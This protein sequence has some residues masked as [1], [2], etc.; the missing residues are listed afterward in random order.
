MNI[1]EEKEK[2]AQLDKEREIKLAELRSK[3][4]TLREEIIESIAKYSNMIDSKK[5]ELKDINNQMCSI[6]G[7]EFTAWEEKESRFVDR[8]WYY[9]RH[10]LVCGK[11]EQTTVTPEEYI[12]KDQHGNICPHK[13]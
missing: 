5:Q 7:H 13:R 10:C 12:S 1:E 9:E 2:L 3:L 4:I 11:S 8:D 6:F